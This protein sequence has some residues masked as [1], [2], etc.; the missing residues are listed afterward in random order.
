MPARRVEPGGTVRPMLLAIPLLG[1]CAGCVL[2]PQVEP[3]SVLL[4]NTLFGPTRVEAVLTTSPFCA[5]PGPGVEARQ[6][7]VLA[8]NATRFIEA[9]TGTNVCWRRR[10][11]GPNH[12]AHWSNW[13]ITYT[14]PGRSID[15]NL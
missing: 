6:E 2:R 7:F 4:T 9:P 11:A 1:A 13:N 10:V 14:Y 15:S 5:Y 12:T 8:N 3:G